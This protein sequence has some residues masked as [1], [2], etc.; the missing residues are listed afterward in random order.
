M[1][2]TRLVLAAGCLLAALT[3]CGGVAVMSID[4][5]AEWVKVGVVSPGVPLDIALNR[6]SK[7]KTP[8][9]VAL[10]DGERIFGEDALTTAVRFP[11][12]GYQYLLPLAGKLL[13]NP[14]VQ[15][16]AARF[17]H[18]Q[19]EKDAG[20][21]TV[22]FRHDAETTFSVEELL[23][24][25]LTQARQTASE[26]T[27]QTVTD[28]VITVPA[29]F[30]QAERRAVLTAAGLAGVKV[31]QLMN[32]NAAVA[33]NYGMFRRNDFNATA[34][35]ILFYDMGA[36]STSATLVGYQLV[37]TK[38]RGI[39]E[40]NPQLQ[41]L[42][43]AYDRT[44]GGL[45]M[46]MRLQQHLAKVFT[47]TKKTKEDVYASPRAMAKLLK[48][49]ERVKKILSAN[50]ETTAQV[51]GLL[52]EEDF[53][54][55][56]SRA[57]FEELCADL[58]TRITEPL[59]TAVKSA[60]V[61]LSQV[62]QLILA[63]AA[64][65]VPRVQEAL[66]ARW[67][68]ELGKS[69]NTDEAA[70]LGAVYRAADLSTGFKVMKF[71]VKDYVMLPI[72]VDFE[73]EAEEHGEA[74]RRKVHR[75]LFTH[76]NPYP[77][78][79]V[80]TFNRS[81]Q[82]FGFT[83]NYGDLGHLAE[84]EIK[85]V[86][87]LNLSYVLLDG[88]ADVYADHSGEGVESKGLKVHFHMGDSG[89]LNLTGVEAV[90]E[91]TSTAPDDEDESTLSKL[92]SAFSN[93]FSGDEGKDEKDGKV[94]E[95]EGA[96]DQAEKKADTKKE[97]AKKEVPKNKTAEKDVNKT[98][99]VKDE[100]PKIRVVKVPIKF[101]ITNLNVHELQGE[102][103]EKSAQKIAD[104]DEQDRQRKRR[105]QA[106]NALESF[107]NDVQMRLYE[108]LYESASTEEERDTIRQ[109]ASEMSD[110]L[111]EEGFHE[112]A[113]V[114]EEKLEEM[115]K[116]TKALFD[117]VEEHKS[118]PEAVQALKDILNVTNHFLTSAD[119]SVK[120]GVIVESDISA[121]KKMLNA[122]KEWL[123][124][125]TKEQD[126]TP[127]T[128]TPKLKIKA[129]ADKYLSLD[130]EIKYVVTKIKVGTAKKMRE[131]ADLKIKEAAAKAEE[132]LKKAKKD[133]GATNDTEGAD[134]ASD[135]AEGAAPAPAEGA[136]PTPLEG[137]TP[138]PAEGAT[139]A[140]VDG[141]TAVP[142]GQAPGAGPAADGDASEENDPE[143]DKRKD[144]ED[145]HSEL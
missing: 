126:K 26:H 119:T 44:L 88:V 70:A 83:V 134:Q 12:L 23:S 133:E 13:T 28:A 108:E 75:N 35:Y 7:R 54:H 87:G 130:K 9:A 39:S 29:F 138:A 30:N 131:E 104:L 73:R 118:R 51:E 41:I 18:Y 17:P 79:K 96:T 142:E 52:D 36:E 1:V 53:R 129:M 144:A 40:T 106:R 46:T 57:E 65:R 59:E 63:G 100:K 89:L 128:Q 143:S 114:F 116:L 50:A 115:K 55:A 113:A 135:Q 110:W 27:H 25:I 64:T 2:R 94:E 76:G 124:S 102:A 69:I 21:G 101:K 123:K 137:A 74:S 112:T 127:L 45:E 97:D 42:G 5:G 24:M 8:A 32:D 43:Y 99:E 58:F 71:H 20:R 82:D 11:A 81:Q 49:A 93:L 61:E 78:K 98:A 105:E 77:Q 145:D 103:L 56:V 68:R 132:E 66:Q 120:E 125:K 34:Q 90:F 80:I 84:E 19:L 38:D 14:A 37:K 136:T 109:K 140:P 107:T 48:E 95:T 33:L 22:L 62:D 139:P 111:Y 92:S 122:S 15:R 60:G 47:N 3:V 86:D 6:E 141:A 67:G 16:F 31:L 117:R 72:G 85:V 121:L 10:R 91:K 4:L